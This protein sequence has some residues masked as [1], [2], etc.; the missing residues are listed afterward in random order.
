MSDF[1]IT[2]ELWLYLK[3]ELRDY[4]IKKTNNVWSKT[5]EAKQIV[6]SLANASK[7]KL[8]F[9][10]FLRRKKIDFAVSMQNKG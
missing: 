4:L 3:L 5:R 6:S 10:T 7:A 1:D 9:R 2:I 8:A